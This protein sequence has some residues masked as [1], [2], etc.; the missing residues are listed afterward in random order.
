MRT[1]RW[2]LTFAGLS[3]LGLTTVGCPEKKPVIDPNLVS[4]V[5]AAA[6]RAESAASQAEAAAKRAA[7]AAAKAEAA[8]DKA[9]S[10]FKEKLR[11]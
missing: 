5:E 9:A 2:A 6:S 11:K 1:V 7:D 3:F 8:A 10:R 4:R